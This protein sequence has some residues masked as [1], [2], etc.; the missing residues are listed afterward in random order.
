MQVSGLIRKRISPAFCFQFLFNPKISSSTFVIKT[1]KSKTSVM[2]IIKIDRMLKILGTVLGLTLLCSA[3]KAA[4]TIQ[5]TSWTNSFPVGTNTTYFLMPETEWWWGNW[6]QCNGDLTNDPAMDAQGNSSSGSAYLSIPFSANGQQGWIYSTFASGGGWNN[7]SVQIPLKDIKQLA[8]DVYVK[9][10]TTKSANGN[11]GWLGMNLILGTSTGGFTAT[12]VP[13]H[14]TELAIPASADGAWVHLYDTNTVSDVDLDITSGY[15]NAAAVAFYINNDNVDNYPSNMSF[16]FYLDN[17]AVTTGTNSS[18]P[19]AQFLM[20]SN[21]GVAPFTVTFQDTSLNSPTSWSWNFGDGGTSTSQNPSHTFTNIWR[22]TVTLTVNNAFGSSSSTQ[23]VYQCFPCDAVYDWTNGTQG[24]I[25][26]VATLSNSLVGGSSKI[27]TFFVT[28]YDIPSPNLQGIIF[29]NLTGMTNGCPVVFSNGVIYSNFN[30]TNALTF[31]WTNNHE[32]FTFS[33]NSGYVVTNIVLIFYDTAPLV[34]NA[35]TFADEINIATTKDNPNLGGYCLNRWLGVAGPL[36]GFQND[37]HT[38]E[39][40]TTSGGV[41]Y[42][43][44]P[45]YTNATFNGSDIYIVANKIYR[46]LLEENTNGNCILAVGDPAASTLTGFVTNWNQYE[47]GDLITAWA[48]GHTSWENFTTN[49]TTI[50]A[51]H[52]I[53]SVNLPLSWFQASNVVMFGP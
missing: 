17:L 14:F 42:G 46:V 16:A 40:L 19:V 3:S 23:A 21:I 45:Y 5:T 34:S 15:T 4:I 36:S 53:I 38:S 25:A 7:G 41:T 11:Y 12:P 48:D 28:N 39:T 49:R 30:T 47:Y 31:N 35:W 9:S 51:Y 52:D 26:T 2:K 44:F 20:S 24:Q 22:Q 8:F 43:S 18:A 50:M 10:G 29:T 37:Y 1:M 32:Q 13:H 27:G 6:D 33:F